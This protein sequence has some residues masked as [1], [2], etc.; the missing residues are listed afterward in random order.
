MRA[1]KD[2]RKGAIDAA[3]GAA[4]FGLILGTLGRQGSPS[5]FRRLKA[6]L[7]VRSR[8]PTSSLALFSFAYTTAASPTSIRSHIAL[9]RL[10]TCVSTVTCTRHRTPGIALP[11]IAGQGQDGGALF[12]G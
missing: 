7:Q 11:G 2:V 3:R 8:T 12:D 1:M 9:F 6:L 4:V 5:I 10:L